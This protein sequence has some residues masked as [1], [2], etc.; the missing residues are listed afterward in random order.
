MNLPLEE[1][2]QLCLQLVL[3]TEKAEAE[4][5]ELKAELAQKEQQDGKD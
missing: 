4:L 5:A 3:R 2:I 1:V